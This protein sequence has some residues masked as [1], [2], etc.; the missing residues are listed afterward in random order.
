MTDQKQTEGRR[1]NGAVPG[2]R[3]DETT[4]EDAILKVGRQSR[5]KAGPDG[6]DA[7]EVGDTFKRKPD[8]AA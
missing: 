4:P 1:R 2:G 6:P 7:R 3:P 5:R 8:P